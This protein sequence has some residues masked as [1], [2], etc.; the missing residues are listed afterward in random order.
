MAGIRVL[1]TRGLRSIRSIPTIFAAFA[2][3]LAAHQHFPEKISCIHNTTYGMPL[4]QRSHLERASQALP[5]SN[6]T[7]ARKF[8]VG[9]LHLPRARTMLKLW[10]RQ[11]ITVV[12]HRKKGDIDQLL[13]SGE[14]MQRC[15]RCGT[16]NKNKR[17]CFGLAQPHQWKYQ[18]TD[19]FFK[20]ESR[21][22]AALNAQDSRA[23]A[24]MASKDA[25][26]TAQG[27]VKAW[28]TTGD[29]KNLLPTVGAGS[30]CQWPRPR[31]IGV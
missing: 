28:P 12:A 20:K 25:V 31:L 23:N 30:F 8:F 3:Q 14:A 13:A 26:K 9:E 29:L 18:A 15:T 27:R 17:S 19:L 22:A 10:D 5:A 24:G 7:N 4:I 2:L 21:S 16:I 11:H 6:G 1:G